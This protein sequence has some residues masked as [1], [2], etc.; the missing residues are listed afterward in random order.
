MFLDNP[1]KLESLNRDDL[2][3]LEHLFSYVESRLSLIRDEIESEESI[4]DNRRIIICL[5]RGV[6][7]DKYSDGLKIKMSG[8]FPKDTID[9]LTRE[10][11]AKLS[12]FLN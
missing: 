1:E 10:I 3:I 4:N 11:N 12:R 6:A 2:I 7:F 8:C 9:F 5:N